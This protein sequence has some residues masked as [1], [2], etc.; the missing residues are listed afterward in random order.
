MQDD[1]DLLEMCLISRNVRMQF[2]VS[3]RSPGRTPLTTPSKSY[4]VGVVASSNPCRMY[5]LWLHLYLC[6]E[7]FLKHGR[8]M[9]KIQFD[10]NSNLRDIG[11]A[12]SNKIVVLLLMFP[13]EPK[14]LRSCMSCSY[15][16]RETTHLILAMLAENSLE[17]FTYLAALTTRITTQYVKITAKDFVDWCRYRFKVSSRFCLAQLFSFEQLWEKINHSAQEPRHD[18]IL[19]PLEA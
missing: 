2:V 18:A 6:I 14:S 9:F 7:M 17:A 16:W 12:M 11:T 8:L 15:D 10:R 13:K 1:V 5:W 19:V 3:D 4:V